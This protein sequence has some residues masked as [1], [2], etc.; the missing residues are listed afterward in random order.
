MTAL[1][2]VALFVPLM[3]LASAQGPIVDTTYGPV[4]G[5]DV[6]LASGTVI[7]TFM[8]IPFARAPVGDLRFE[9]TPLYIH[10]AQLTYSK[11]ICYFK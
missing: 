9:V 2:C 8:G 1:A 5:V 6:P 4:Q 3:A 10:R 11:L 7:Q